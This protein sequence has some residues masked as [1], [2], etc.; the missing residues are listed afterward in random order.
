MKK[1]EEGAKADEEWLEQEEMVEML[2]VWKVENVTLG[3][4]RVQNQSKNQGGL[5]QKL[6]DFYLFL[7][8]N[9]G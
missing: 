1:E 5:S 6:F 7:K 8:S 4:S 2:R 3:T 9:V